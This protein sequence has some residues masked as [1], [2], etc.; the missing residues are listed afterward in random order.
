[1]E[2]LQP[3]LDSFEPKKKYKMQPLDDPQAYHMEGDY[4][5]V[6]ADEA[7]RL[8]SKFVKNTLVTAKLP[9]PVAVTKESVVMEQP[10]K[11]LTDVTE[12]MVSDLDFT[13]QEEVLGKDPDD[14][15]NIGN[16]ELLE[17]LRKT[18]E[19]TPYINPPPKLDAR[20]LKRLLMR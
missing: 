1:M 16:T 2:P 14:F 3:K 15:F 10:A 19:V 11:N 8:R 20:Q 6:N 7:I 12:T 18:Q 17:K 4:A 9:T 5:V 13:Q